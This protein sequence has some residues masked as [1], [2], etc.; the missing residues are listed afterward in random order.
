MNSKW[1]EK[2]D[3]ITAFLLFMMSTI[4]LV[5]AFYTPPFLNDDTLITLTY[6]KNLAAGNGFVFNHP[7]PVLGT[8]TPLLT[9]ILALFA[10]IFT[11]IE[12]PVLAVFFTTFCWLGI[13]WVLFFYRKVWR[14]KNRDVLIIALVITLSPWTGYLGME[15]YL[16][17]FLLTLT[18]SIFLKKNYFVT[19]ILTCL[20]FLTRGE[21]V[22]LLGLFALALITRQLRQSVF[23]DRTLVINIS[24][25]LAGFAFPA[26]LW[27]IYA[28][29]T[30]GA[31][32]PNTMAAKQAQ[33]QSSLWPSFIFQLFSK[34]LPESNDGLRFSNFPFANF[35]WLIMI[36]GVFQI[37]LKK[38][39][40]LL[41]T[42]WI[43][44][45][46]VGYAI[47]NVPAYTWYQLPVLFI[48]N[49]IFAMGV[50]Q[51]VDLIFHYIKS[52]RLAFVL[53][54]LISIM[55][56]FF[57]AK[58]A[59]EKTINFKGDGR[60]YAYTR[61]ADWLN[62]NTQ[63]DESVAFIE[64]GYLGFYSNNR[65]IDL[66]GLVLPEIPDKI[67]TKDFAWGFWHYNPDY[68]IYKPSFDQAFGN[69]ISDPRFE[70]QYCAVDTL[71]DVGNS[72]FIIY[73]LKDK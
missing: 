59:I 38:Q 23:L 48:I 60:G 7:P 53:A 31:I 28:L 46:L 36:L 54:G 49:I 5:I 61:I 63:P 22:L 20:L 12:I 6:V 72:Q 62:K 71:P 51:L 66:A 42:G 17:A 8:T 30:F 11:K 25:L 58:P 43:L 41:F 18:L 69:I 39:R 10:M 52:K 21:G 29:Y 16:F 45:Y 3:H 56:I 13:S 27:A 50:I 47:L 40:F 37:T 44:L 70:L 65:I 55:V 24:K 57:N 68:Y 14:L 9:I 15:A 1:L 64:I 19:G 2:S 73:K 34:W 32:L 26:F 67:V 33:G 35:W 4:P